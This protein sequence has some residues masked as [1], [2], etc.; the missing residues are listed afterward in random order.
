MIGRKVARHMRSH[1]VNATIHQLRHTFGTEAARASGG[2]LLV[3]AEM[4]GHES[5]STTHGYVRLAGSATAATV[6]AMF[7]PAA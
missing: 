2:N 1:G 3:V 5:L 4:M 6:A 7:P